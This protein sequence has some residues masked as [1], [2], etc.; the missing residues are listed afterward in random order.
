MSDDPYNDFLTAF[1][2]ALR[3][4]TAFFPKSNRV[5]IDHGV[6][7]TGGDYWFICT[8]GAF[9]SSRESGRSRIYQWQTECD[10]YIR[11][12]SE[13]DSMPKLI[14]SRGALIAFIT[15]PRLV[16]DV[17]LIKPLS[18]SGGRL[19]QDVTGDNPNFLIQPLIVTAEQS[20]AI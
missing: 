5:G 14:A 18:V 15:R 20:V 10:F 3:T 4:L 17:G 7:E 9:P 12:K 13:K 8:P 19:V 6:V 16:K 2:I 11:Y 1:M